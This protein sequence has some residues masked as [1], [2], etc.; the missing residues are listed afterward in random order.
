MQKDFHYDVIYVL[1]TWAGF[2]PD[3]ARILAYASQYVDDAN[4]SG[5]IKFSNGASYTRTSSAHESFDV[6]HNADDVEN[7]NVWL[8]F[9]FLPG[10]GGHPK[11]KGEDISLIERIICTPDSFVAREMVKE[12]INNCDKPYGLHRFG[13]AMHTYADTWAHWGFAGVKDGV[14]KVKE[15]SRENEEGVFELLDLAQ[16]AESQAIGEALP[17]GH[18]P[19]LHNPDLPFLKKWKFSFIEDLNR[20]EQTYPN[21]DFFLKAAENIIKSMRAFIDYRQSHVPLADDL[22]A[23]FEKYSGLTNEQKAIIEDI[24]INVKDEEENKRHEIWR[25][26]AQGGEIPGISSI[27]SYAAKNEG[28]WKFDAVGAIG[29]K[30][31]LGDIFEY[32]S[33]FINSDWKKFH[34]GLQMQRSYILLELLPSYGICVS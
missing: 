20:G 16:Q 10:N 17:V 27:P 18:G 34:D 33:N 32:D 9:H 6:I 26:K 4:N 25:D 14:N 24:F 30:D 7:R 15:I 31:T 1:A 19:A 21:T 12:A 22:S 29:E 23:L 5:R 11:G 8:P 3:E 2:N 28:S 13:I